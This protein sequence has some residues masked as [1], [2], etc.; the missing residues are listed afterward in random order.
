MRSKESVDKDE[1]VSAESLCELARP[2]IQAKA[3]KLV[4]KAGITHSDREDIEQEAYLRLVQRLRS[5]PPISCHPMVV[6]L[7]VIDQSIA[8]QL[9]DR[10]A[11]KRD[12]LSVRSL[13]GSP[14]DSKSRDE[15]GDRVSNLDADR[16][17]ECRSQF[18]MADLGLDL[19]EVIAELSR[20]QQELC[21]ALGIESVSELARRLETPRTTLNDKV[22]TVRR[23]LE[24][25]GLEDYL[26]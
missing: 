24:D 14:N 25:R 23:A 2:L 17:R 18:E 15:L 6:I 4:G 1:A 21:E 12:P 16:R 7:R 8:N 11:K 22:R 20:D 10:T 19:E 5:G 9:R 26:E 3:R 13:Y